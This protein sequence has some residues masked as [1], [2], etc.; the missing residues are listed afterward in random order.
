MIPQKRWSIQLLII[1]RILCQM[2]RPLFALGWRTYLIS[3]INPTIT[4][5]VIVV[6]GVTGP[7]IVTHV[8]I[9]ILIFPAVIP[10]D[11]DLTIH[12]PYIPQQQEPHF[13]PDRSEGQRRTPT[14]IA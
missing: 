9:V 3:V 7:S 14:R 4:S 5:V 1:T 8:C 11:L 13:R 2:H 6:S 10:A 12:R